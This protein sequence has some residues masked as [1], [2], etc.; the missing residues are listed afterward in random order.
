MIIEFLNKIEKQQALEF[1]NNILSNNFTPQ[2]I[3][4]STYDMVRIIR[5][6]MPDSY[7]NYMLLQNKDILIDDIL[8]MD[9][10]SEEE[11]Q[12]EIGALISRNLNEYT[13]LAKDI[14]EKIRSDEMEAKNNGYCPGLLNDVYEDV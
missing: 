13:T 7:P 5:K 1:C 11:K 10:I 9:S 3:I 14:L 2:Y 12:Y 6:I 4:N 8:E